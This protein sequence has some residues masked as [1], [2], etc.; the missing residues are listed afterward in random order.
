MV[1]LGL[2]AIGVAAA[3]GIHLSNQ[4][5]DNLWATLLARYAAGGRS[6]GV[7]AALGALA[8]N[9]FVAGVLAIVTDARKLSLSNPRTRTGFAIMWAGAEALAIGVIAGQFPS[10]RNDVLVEW[11]DAAGPVA[12]MLVALGIM[13]V[14][15]G[16][17][18]D[19][20][21]ASDVLATDTRPPVIY[22]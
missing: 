15:T 9:L 18:H 6:L 12:V 7:F 20:R 11:V 19:V 2:A 16:W 4:I 21:G 8:I 5:P 3:L 17:K 10:G 1:R 14:R 13:L 22:L